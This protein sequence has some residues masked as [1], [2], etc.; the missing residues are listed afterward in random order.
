MSTEKSISIVMTTYNGEYY[1]KDQLDSL[2]KQTIP[3]EEL[4]IQD[5]KSKDHTPDIVKE[6]ASTDNRIKFYQN[7]KNLGWNINFITAIK[8]AKGEYIALCDQDD[9]WYPQKLEKELNQI[10]SHS[11][12]FCYRYKDPQYTTQGKLLGKPQPEMESLL[13]TSHIPGHG[14]I[15][16]RKLIEAIDTWHERIP[17]DWWLAIQAHIH[18]G[19]TYV[20]EPLNWHRPHADS[21][22]SIM[23]KEEWE[24]A[25]KITWQ[26]YVYG[27]KAYRRFQQMEDWQWLYNY[28]ETHTY[29]ER[30]SLVNKMAKL[31]QRPGIIP[32]LKLCRLTMIHR[33]KVHERFAEGKGIKQILG[34]I[35]GFFYPLM[36]TY[37]NNTSFIQKPKTK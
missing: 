11:L 6:Y 17:Y 4:I 3:F 5:D 32:L 31:L 26:P 8:R 14:M 33:K 36:W 34:L 12:C 22:S 10:G 7:E 2:L 35:R 23:M 25:K 13:F 27:W 24:K 18:D 19:V 28:I 21:A 29:G 37:N 30:H 20:A 9:I 16:S 15:V 1:L